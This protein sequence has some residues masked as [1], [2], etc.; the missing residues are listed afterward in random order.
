MLFGDAAITRA[1][2]F[3]VGL[4]GRDTTAQGKA[5]ERSELA[6][7]LSNHQHKPASP[8]RAKYIEANE[9]SA[10]TYGLQ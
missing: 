7:A 8:E 9:E 6:A 5:S 2:D 10:S 1:V 4:K 3:Y